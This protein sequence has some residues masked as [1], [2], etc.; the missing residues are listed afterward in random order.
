M[1]RNAEAPMEITPEIAARCE[2]PDQFKKF[3]QLV[4]NVMAG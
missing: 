3:D 4:R 1:N 2:G